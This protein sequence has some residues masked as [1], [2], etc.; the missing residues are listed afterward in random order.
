MDSSMDKNLGLGFFV[1]IAIVMLL[2]LTIVLF[3]KE[4]LE[5]LLD[6]QSA[7]YIG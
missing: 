7:K 4:I 5:V 3:A 1:L 6:E 2:K